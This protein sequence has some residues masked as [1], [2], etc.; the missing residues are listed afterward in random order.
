MVVGVRL[1]VCTLFLL[2][3]LAFGSEALQEDAQH[4]DTKFLAG[5]AGRFSVAVVGL[6][7]ALIRLGGCCGLLGVNLAVL[8]KKS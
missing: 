3:F 7:A 1:L 4:G 2:V 8:L 5:V 6:A